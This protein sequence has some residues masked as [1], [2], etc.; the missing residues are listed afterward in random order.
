[1]AVVQTY[2]FQQQ[3]RQM[4]D[5]VDVI[6][7]KMP[8]LFGLIGTGGA[9]TQTKFEWQNDYLNSDIVTASTTYSDSAT[10]IVLNSGEGDRVTVNSLLQNGE[11]VIRVTAVS[12]DTLTVTR[13]Y[14]S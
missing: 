5:N 7:A 6:L 1:M 4:A 13:E 11:E 10:S 9:L 2:D 8:V 14:D 12:S 3:I